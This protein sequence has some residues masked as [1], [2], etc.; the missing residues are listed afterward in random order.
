[1]AKKYPFRYNY[2]RIGGF[3]FF[4]EAK[5]IRFLYKGKRYAYPC[6]NDKDFKA[7]FDFLDV[8]SSLTNEG[9]SFYAEC[10]TECR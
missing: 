8:Y 5:T 1:M 4:R 2:A 9:A 3:E 10:C 6:L 7:I